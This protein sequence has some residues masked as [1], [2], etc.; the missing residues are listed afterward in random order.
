M[1]LPPVSAIKFTNKS[2]MVPMNECLLHHILSQE[3]QPSRLS[4]DKAVF[5][6]ISGLEFP[7]KLHWSK[8]EMPL[9][10]QVCLVGSQPCPCSLHRARERSQEEEEIHFR[11]QTHLIPAHGHLLLQS[12]TFYVFTYLGSEFP[13]LMPSFPCHME[14]V[15]FT[16]A[17]VSEKLERR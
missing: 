17:E 8:A 1:V 5:A 10:A 16:V 3:L 15:T 6:F 12:Y 13:L 2:W 9:A 14:L 4:L 7:Y 11:K